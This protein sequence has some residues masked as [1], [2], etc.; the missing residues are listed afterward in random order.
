MWVKTGSS[1]GKFVLKPFA[2]QAFWLSKAGNT[3][4]EYEDAF[5]CSIPD[6]RFAV[7]DGATDSAFAGRWAQGLVKEFVASPPSSPCDLQK[8]LEPLQN[9]WRESIDWERLPWHGE[10]K[11][12]VGAFSSLLGLAF[13]EGESSHAQTLHW[14]ALAVGDSCLFQVRDDAL[15]VAF[16]LESA[17]QFGNRPLLLSS[18]PTRNQRVWEA[19]CFHE[20]DCQPDDQF[21][22]MTDA[23]AHWFL[24]HHEARANPWAALC[25]LKTQEEFSSFVAALRQAGLIRNDDTTL[26]MVRLDSVALNFRA[27]I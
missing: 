11:A 22:L 3:A 6:S 21:F 26:L 1:G 2:A 20:D 24:A 18:Q 12:K 14:S 27:L 17:K 4:E 10:E 23:L 19:I 13:I 7:A 8:W 5:E 16:P 25:G 9:A 15:Q